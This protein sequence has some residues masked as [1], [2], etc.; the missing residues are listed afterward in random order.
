MRRLYFRDDAKTARTPT[1]AALV[2]A[3][4]QS[5]TTKTTPP[6]AIARGDVAVSIC[7]LRDSSASR[8][9]QTAFS[10]HA[11]GHPPHLASRSERSLAPTMPLLSKS[12]APALPHMDKSTARSGAPVDPLPSRSVVQLKAQDVA[13]QD[14]CGNAL[15][16]VVFPAGALGAGGEGHDV[17]RGV[18]DLWNGHRGRRV[19]MSLS[20]EGVRP[21]R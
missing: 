7:A 6:L 1:L 14:H 15:S 18:G 17:L 20:Q 11:H 12:A 3:R 4:R 2:E 16:Y 5:F 9:M 10:Q 19:S 8:P 21:E 13:G